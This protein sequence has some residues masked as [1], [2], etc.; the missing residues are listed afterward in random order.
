[1]SILN[2]SKYIGSPDNNLEQFSLKRNGKVLRHG[3]PKCGPDMVLFSP[4][5]DN[6]V[7]A[8]A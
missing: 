8:E 2:N 4:A 1:M 3:G 5:R 7:M 6:H